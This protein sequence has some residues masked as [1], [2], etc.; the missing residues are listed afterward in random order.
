[1]TASDDLREQMGILAPHVVPGYAMLEVPLHK[2]SN[3]P[4][5]SV[6]GVL[7]DTQLEPSLTVLHPDGRLPL[8]QKCV[9]TLAELPNV[10]SQL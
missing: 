4:G 8:T 5:Q 10:G 7:F 9:H 2:Y 6:D 3:S 1:M